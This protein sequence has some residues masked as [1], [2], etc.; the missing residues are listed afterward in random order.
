[1]RDKEDM[2][3]ENDNEVNV[4]NEE[5]TKETGEK[6]ETSSDNSVSGDGVV[7]K[8]ASNKHRT[9]KKRA[10]K[11]AELE[12]AADEAED[13]LE[14]VSLSLSEEDGEEYIEESFEDPF[15]EAE[16]EMSDEEKAL[17]KAK[18]NKILKRVF[19]AI[20][21]VILAAYLGIS[22][23]F[24]NHFYFNTKINGVNFSAKT[25]EDVEA[26][27]E[28]QVKDYELTLDESDGDKEIISGDVISLS[29][30]KGDELKTLVKKQNPLLWPTALWKTPDITAKV[31]VSYDEEELQTIIAGLECMKEENQTPP[32]SA[33]PEFDGTKFVPKAEEVGSQ[34]DKEAFEK[35]V[36]EYIEGFRD[37][38]DMTEESCYVKPKYN[39]ESKEVADACEEM[40][41]YLKASVTYTFGS[42][43][44]V[45]DAKTISQW[46]VTDENM[47]VTF[48]TDAVMQY[49]QGLADKYNTYQKQRSFTSGSG[50]AVTVEGGD[51]GWIIDKDTEYAALVASIQ[52]G[53]TVTKEPAYSQTAASHDA[54]DWGTTYVELDLTNQYVYLFVDGAVVTS[55]PCVT[56]LPSRG[57]AT[58]PGVYSIKY[59]QANT[60][61]RGPKLEN[62]E[63]EWESPVSFWMPFNGGIGLHDAPWQAAF[64]GNRYL[65]HGS[66]GCVN[67][68][69]NVAQTIF[70]TVQAGTPVV[71]HY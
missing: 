57:D 34:I 26:Y 67:L 68:Q 37:T 46:V 20:G 7:R 65:T 13:I 17:R 36:Y 15:E 11:E 8:T 39:I 32:V 4:E 61:L 69:Y 3:K 54:A 10:K 60:T 19:G 24:I 38:L 16:E 12:L 71:C 56:G 9:R 29:Y 25:V 31:G 50:N 5:K 1:M 18:R 22:A 41:K 51:Y 6:A 70:N 52:N 30:E 35:K 55:G 28:E 63:Y 66:R 62:G 27:M 64:G 43:S 47:A 40:N 58:P 48:N 45:V 21:A 59:C 53:E 33:L 42:A 44:E 49:I 2:I 14:E 23:F